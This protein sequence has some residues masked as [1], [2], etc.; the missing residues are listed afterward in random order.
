MLEVLAL[1]FQENLQHLAPCTQGRILGPNTR[2]VGARKQ[3]KAAG[4]PF[5]KIA[6]YIVYSCGS[7]VCYEFELLTK[8]M[9]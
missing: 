3:Q 2:T 4:Q 9:K 8:L 6:L 5:T 7:H 1:L